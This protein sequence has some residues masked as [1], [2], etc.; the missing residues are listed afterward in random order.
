MK[1][2]TIK[3]FEN[4]EEIKDITSTFYFLY[5]VKGYSNK[6]FEFLKSL[7]LTDEQY[8]KL[9]EMF[10]DYGDY[11]YEDGIWAGQYSMR[12]PY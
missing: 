8:S 10:S 5:N 2:K 9:S 4:F 7:N 12:D 11:K 1:D 3:K 6:E